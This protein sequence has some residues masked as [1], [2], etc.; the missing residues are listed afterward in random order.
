MDAL[1]EGLA[2]LFKQAYQQ[3]VEDGRKQ[4]LIEPHLLDRKDLNGAFGITKDALDDY[5]LPQPDFPFIMQG[6]RKKYYAPAVHQWLLNH[7]ETIN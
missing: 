4:P 2:N 5:Y 3:G 7:Q 1:T 6:S